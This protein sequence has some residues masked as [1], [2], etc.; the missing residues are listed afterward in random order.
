MKRSLSTA[1]ILGLLVL[2]AIG[3]VGCGHES[4]VEKTET[5]TGPG[6]TTSSSSEVKVKSTG[7]NPPPN[8]AGQTAK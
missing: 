7:E 3:L 1:L 4:K 6:G 5:V 2:P 8:S